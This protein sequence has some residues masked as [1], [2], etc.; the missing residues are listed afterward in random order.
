MF[1]EEKFC[2]FLTVISGK[3]EYTKLTVVCAPRL[4]ERVVGWQILQKHQLLLQ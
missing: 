2:E 1:D 4:R 3:E